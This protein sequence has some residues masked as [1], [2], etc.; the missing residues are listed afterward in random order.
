MP[1]FSWKNCSLWVQHIHTYI[2][3]I[4]HDS[5]YVAQCKYVMYYAL[6]LVR[7]W[8]YV[9]AYEK[10]TSWGK[11]MPHNCGNSY[12]QLATVN[13]AY[14]NSNIRVEIVPTRA[15]FI[16]SSAWPRWLQCKVRREKILTSEARC[17]AGGTYIFMCC[18]I[19]CVLMYVHVENKNRIKFIKSAK[20]RLTLHFALRR[21]RMRTHANAQLHTRTHIYSEHSLVFC[22][23]C[24][25]C[26][27]IS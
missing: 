4:C 11:K 25:L 13:K 19:V 26:M 17:S 23:F 8:L 9:C 2:F 24:Q 15:D 6:H 16:T 18:V 3:T 12:K 22:L 20:Q 21:L 14:N 10:Q 27:R 1:C 7:V 5:C